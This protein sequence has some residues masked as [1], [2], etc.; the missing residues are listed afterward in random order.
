[1]PESSPA[2]CR[3]AIRDRTAFCF[4]LRGLLNLDSALTLFSFSGREDADGFFF[5]I[6]IL[7]AISVYNSLKKSAAVS[8]AMLP[9]FSWLIRF[10]LQSHS[11]TPLYKMYTNQTCG[12]HGTVDASIKESIFGYLINPGLPPAGTPSANFE[13][14]SLASM[15]RN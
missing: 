11:I 5:A 2:A 6:F 4:S 1:M 12:S 15:R 14:G 10:F 13:T 3:F 7:H 9:C 8:N